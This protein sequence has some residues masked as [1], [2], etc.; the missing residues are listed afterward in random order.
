LLPQT[1][2]QQL[3]LFS[4]PAYPG[5]TLNIRFY[6][7]GTNLSTELPYLLKF[8]RSGQFSDATTLA[9]TLKVG[10]L[11]DRLLM[12]EE[13]AEAAVLAHRTCFL[14]QRTLAAFAA[15]WERLRL[16]SLAAL[17][18]AAFETA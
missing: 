13:V 4:S 8:L 6:A 2:P 9:N 10:A 18:W 1:R 5:F 17:A 3:F 16:L 12:A 14:L 11:Q 7:A 15:I